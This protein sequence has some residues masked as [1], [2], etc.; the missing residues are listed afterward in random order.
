MDIATAATQSPGNAARLVAL[1]LGEAGTTPPTTGR[2]DLEDRH[3]GLGIDAD[4]TSKVATATTDKDTAVVRL[5]GS[6]SSRRL[7]ELRVDGLDILPTAVTALLVLLEWARR[8]V[9]LSRVLALLPLPASQE[10]TTPTHSTES[11]RRLHRRLRETP[12]L[13]LPAISRLRRHLLARK[14]ADK[15][16][17]ILVY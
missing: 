11:R 6:N 5:L 16:E 2:A 17:L 8:L 3:H 4:R 14:G 10:L 1:L 13:P 12:L 7:P 15:I 9:F